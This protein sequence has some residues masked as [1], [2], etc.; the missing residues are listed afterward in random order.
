MRS[1]YA[2]EVLADAPPEVGIFVEFYTNL[3][4]R[5]NSI[6]KQKGITQKELAQ[7][8]GKQPSEISKWLSGEHNFTLRSIAKLQAELGEV[9]IEI[10]KA[11][12]E[13]A[14]SKASTQA[15]Q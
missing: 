7:S 8:L 3:T 10:P 1:K 5:V 6:L 2:D 13:S 12:P 4:M 14:N 11:E 9:L 15:I